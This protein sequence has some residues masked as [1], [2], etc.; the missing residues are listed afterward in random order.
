MGSSWK[1]VT[2]YL[3]HHPG[4]LA[5]LTHAEALGAGLCANLTQPVQTPWREKG[6]LP[7]G[8]S[9]PLHS[10]WPQ[11]CTQLRPEVL[12]SFCRGGVPRNKDRHV[13]LCCRGSPAQG[14]EACPWATVWVEVGQ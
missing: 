10:T 6:R 7:A 14:G 2:L 1:T 5:A 4:C 8:H 3:C 13:T 11:R 9:A 12:R